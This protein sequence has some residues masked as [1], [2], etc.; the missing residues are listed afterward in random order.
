MGG[1]IQVCSVFTRSDCTPGSS[2]RG[3]REECLT[4]QL[5]EQ[6]NQSEGG[7]VRG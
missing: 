7:G 1:H 3:G 6:T 5:E 4:L 2:E